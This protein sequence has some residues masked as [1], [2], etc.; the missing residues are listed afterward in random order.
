MHIKIEESLK[1]VRAMQTRNGVRYI[2]EQPALMFTEHEN[3]PDK[4][5]ITLTI[6][7]EEHQANNKQPLEVGDYDY[8]DKC[9]SVN[10]YGSCEFRLTPEN[11]TSRA[12]SLQKAS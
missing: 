8:T 12:K 10:R 4:C 11:M 3:Y 1:T 2:A 5:T 6:A 7:N 9:F